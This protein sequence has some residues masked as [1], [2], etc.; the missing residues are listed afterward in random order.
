MYGA[1]QGLWR[2]PAD[3]RVTEFFRDKKLYI[4]DGHHRF[5]TARA[6]RDTMRQE[7]SGTAPQ[8]YDYVLMGFVSFQD[9]GLLIYPPHR[10][11]ETPDGF[12]AGPFL[13]A[14]EPWFEVTSVDAGL[15]ERV[16]AASGCAIGVAI[17][18]AGHFLLTLRDIDRVE[19]LGNDRQPAWRELDVAVLHRGIIERLLGLDEGTQLVY[20]GSADRAVGAVARGEKGLAFILKAVRP[21]QLRA[22]AEAG[23]PMPPKSTYFFP[24]LPSGLVIH[25]LV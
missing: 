2:V 3:A 4:A 11:V 21:S 24:K 15:V 20:E 17:R 12:E 18:D 16:E 7:A 23:E 6:Y 22:C 5:E 9:P 8:P 1:T 10:L 19:L 14:L 13:T 25:R